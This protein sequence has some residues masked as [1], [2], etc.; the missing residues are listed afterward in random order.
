MVFGALVGVTDAYSLPLVGFT[1]RDPYLAG[2]VTLM[3]ESF[4]LTY[5]FSLFNA[6][7]IGS[8]SSIPGSLSEVCLAD[9]AEFLRIRVLFRDSRAS[10]LYN[11]DKIFYFVASLT[12]GSVR[13]T[14]ESRGLFL[15]Y[16][17][18]ISLSCS[19]SS[20]DV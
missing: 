8:V 10:L 14:S 18:P 2:A 15:L 19:K 20:S 6:N 3:V 7:S 17:F 9:A 4:L 5:D 16:F 13:S 1:F 12:N 11:F